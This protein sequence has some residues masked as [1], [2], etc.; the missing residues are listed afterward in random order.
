[1]KNSKKI[2][3]ISK[4]IE[5]RLREMGVSWEMEH[6]RPMRNFAALTP[7]GPDS[8]LSRGDFGLAVEEMQY[9]APAGIPT[10]YG[11]F[12]GS[13]GGYTLLTLQKPNGEV[14]VS[15]HNFSAHE[16]YFKALG[17][18]KAAFKSGIF[19]ENQEEV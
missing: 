9:K 16:N 7:Q 19:A 12:V 3:E 5:D 1:M 11:N 2:R 15:K 17:F 10:A 6:I 13:T 14:V 8:I 18:M 4:N